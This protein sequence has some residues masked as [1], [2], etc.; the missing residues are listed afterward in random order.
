MDPEHA[1]FTWIEPRLLAGSTTMAHHMCARVRSTGRAAAL[2]VDPDDT[3]AFLEPLLYAWVAT[4]GEAGHLDWILHGY[5]SLGSAPRTVVVPTNRR[6]M[7][8]LPGIGWIPTGIPDAAVELTDDGAGRFSW[9]GQ[10]VRHCSAVDAGRPCWPDSTVDGHEHPSIRSLFP[11]AI[12]LDPRSEDLSVQVATAAALIAT[13]APALAGLLSAV[14]RRVQ[15]FDSSHLDSFTAMSCHGTIFLNTRLVRNEIGFVE[16]LARQSGHVLL[17][18]CLHDAQPVFDD[19]P[20]ATTC[21]E[22]GGL[23]H[24]WPALL[25]RTFAAWTAM[26]CLE[27]ILLRGGLNTLQAH[28]TVGR[29]AYVAVKADTAVGQLL[30]A[31]LSDSGVTFVSDLVGATG[32]ILERWSPLLATCDLK[33][34]PYAFDRELFLKR[35]PLRPYAA[36]GGQ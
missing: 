14:L 2:A 7:A 5:R 32:E 10:G 25:H 6:G 23:E 8:C 12:G 13:T 33:G 15:L 3:H 1:L 9:S 29:L 34:Q 31:P 19:D 18:T 35:N 17:D 16:E 21:S 26:H 28:E 36:S 22:G 11:E 27:A 20:E 30:S 24:S 4:D